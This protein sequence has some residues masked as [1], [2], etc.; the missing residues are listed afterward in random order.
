ME[1]QKLIAAGYRF[2]VSSIIDELKRKITK[3]FPFDFSNTVFDLKIE[4]Q[5]AGVF[6]SSNA[7]RMAREFIVPDEKILKWYADKKD[8]ECIGTIDAAYIGAGKIVLEVR[9]G[10][11]SFFAVVVNPERYRSTTPIKVDI[12]NKKLVRVGVER[13]TVRLTPYIFYA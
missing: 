1:G 4:N 8:H 6:F 3:R 2:P 13:I 12:L 7:S 10:N 5:G 11:D 9:A